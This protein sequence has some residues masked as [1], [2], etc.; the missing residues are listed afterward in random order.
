M[1]A[2]KLEALLTIPSGTVRIV[3][4][5]SVE[6]AKNIDFT[7]GKTYYHSTA[8]NDSV[9]FGARFQALLDT[10]FSGGTAPTFTV[11]HSGGEGGTGKYSVTPSAGTIEFTGTFH[12]A[13]AEYTG[14]EGVGPA[15]PATSELYP[16][17]W[18][19][20]DCPCARAYGVSDPGHDIGDLV[21]TKAPDGTVISTEYNR[22][23]EYSLEWLYVPDTKTRIN[24]NSSLNQ[25]QAFQRFHRQCILGEASWCSPGGPIRWHA[26]AD[27]DTTYYDYKIT[28][29]GSFKAAPAFE[30]LTAYYPI[31]IPRMIQVPS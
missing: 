3:A 13:L 12:E 22:Y 4:T 1:P 20:A 6:G 30:G 2:G 5:H 19:S 14:L 21:S 15:S 16:D 10:A 23:T 29:M 7:A 9:T 31:A 24:A 17:G 28:D 18:W 27:D 11:S 26:D 25:R 8:G